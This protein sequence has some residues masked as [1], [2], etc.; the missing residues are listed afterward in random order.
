MKTDHRAID[1][2]LASEKRAAALRVADL[3]PRLLREPDALLE[4]RFGFRVLPVSH[5]SRRQPLANGREVQAP[6]CSAY[7]VKGLPVNRDGFVE[8]LLLQ[9]EI[10]GLCIHIYLQL[11][12]RHLVLDRLGPRDRVFEV[13]RRFLLTPQH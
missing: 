1:A 7:A 12:A 6:V 4:L 2:L 13:A 3:S 8:L 11:Q 10:A 5:I 9:V